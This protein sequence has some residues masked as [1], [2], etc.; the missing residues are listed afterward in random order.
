MFK[1]IVSTQNKYEF[2]SID[3]LVPDN[4]LLRLNDKYIDLSFLLEKVR[5]YYSDV[6][7]KMMFIGFLWN[8]IRATITKRNRNEC[9]L[10]L[11]FSS[12][13]ALFSSSKYSR[14]STSISC[15]ENL[16]Y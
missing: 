7:F 1:P 12:S 14:V 6:L 3:E 9:C 8:P 2:I 4:H 10:P 5:P 13:T 11:V 15:F 16:F